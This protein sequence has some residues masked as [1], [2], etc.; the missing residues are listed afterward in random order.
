[1]WHFHFRDFHLHPYQYFRHSYKNIYIL[2]THYY[3]IF[4][5]LRKT[6]TLR[7]T[8]GFYRTLTP[9]FFYTL[10]YIPSHCW[11]QFN[12]SCV[13]YSYICLLKVMQLTKI[14]LVDPKCVC[15]P[16]RRNA[17]EFSRQLHNSIHYMIE[18]LMRAST[19]MVF[20]TNR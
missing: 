12:A 8:Q 1:M 11:G 19:S 10:S 20:E 6:K 17:R 7:K 2:S 16:K 9:Q 14:M 4:I 13:S 3:P 5:S 18:R 15:A